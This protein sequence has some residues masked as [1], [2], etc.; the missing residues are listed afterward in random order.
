M[1]TRNDMCKAHYTSQPLKKA[2]AV[3]PLFILLTFLNQ[4]HVLLSMP[5]WT[6]KSMQHSKALP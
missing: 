2:V 1:K 6:L 5:F 4:L 3:Y